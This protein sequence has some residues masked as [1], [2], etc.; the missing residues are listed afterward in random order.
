[1]QFGGGGGTNDRHKKNFW[2]EGG[3]QLPPVPGASSTSVYIVLC[4]L[5]MGAA[6]KDTGDY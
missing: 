3:G 6:T 1:M 2:G 4:S 5:H